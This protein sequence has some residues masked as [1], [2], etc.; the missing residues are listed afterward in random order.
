MSVMR[1]KSVEQ[2]IK[3]TFTKDAG[4]D[5]K[6]SIGPIVPIVVGK[7]ADAIKMQR[8]LMAQGF[9]LQAI[10][11]PTVPS[12]TSRLRLTIV[13]DFTRAQMDSAVDAIIDAGRKMKLV[14]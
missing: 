9:F 10:R 1:T 5:L 7:D 11:P 3:D 13:R 12:G 4:F 6:D 14:G 2:A 8:M